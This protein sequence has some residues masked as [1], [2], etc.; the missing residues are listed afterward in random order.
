MSNIIFAFAVNDQDEFE[1]RHFGDSDKFLIY[2]WNEENIAS[3]KIEENKFKDLDET[4]IHGSRK[5]GSAIIKFLKNKGVNALV[6]KQFGRN[7]KMINQHFIPVITSTNH[8]DDVVKLLPAHIKH[9]ANE[10]QNQPE[11]YKLIDLRK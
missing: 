9:I 1:K 3:I 6:S 5:K 8:V 11:N 7:I 4:H 2:E 10:I